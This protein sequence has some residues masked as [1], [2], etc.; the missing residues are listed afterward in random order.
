ME[1]RETRTDYG[2]RDRVL[3][4]ALPQLLCDLGPSRHT[5]KWSLRSPLDVTTSARFHSIME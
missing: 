3:L 4:P 2:S 1:G 5:M